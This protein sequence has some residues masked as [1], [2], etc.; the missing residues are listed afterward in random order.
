MTQFLID[1]N[2]LIDAYD[3]YYPQGVFDNVWKWI[4]ANPNILITNRVYKEL[5]LDENG[6]SDWVK[7]NLIS[8][9]IDEEVA[10]EEYAEV[11]VFLNTGNRW[12]GGGLA[13]WVETDTKADPWL[14]A[15]AKKINATIVTHEKLVGPDEGINSTKEPK[16]PFVAQKLG[17]STISLWDLFQVEAAHF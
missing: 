15:Y 10:V 2:A 4:G 5:M 7:K 3:R 14:V 1:T 13:E 11:Q 9:K 16:I 6:L 12:A 8:R 17:V